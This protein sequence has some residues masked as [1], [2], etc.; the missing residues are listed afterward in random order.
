MRHRPENG[1]DVVLDMEAGLEHLG[2]GTG[3]YVDAMLAAIEPYYRSLE[4]GRRVAELADEL[5]ISRTFAV[6][7]KIRD[8][9]DRDAVGDFCERHG[10]EVLAW[11]PYDRSLV[12]AE[13]EGRAPMDY[14]ADS[15]AVAAIRDIAGD[16][17]NG[18]GG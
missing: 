14:D 15:P 17:L 4:T 7:N 2:R 10:L 5:G 1:E 11:I 8:D 6:A 13:R 18:S 12:E 16:L 9:S 3:R